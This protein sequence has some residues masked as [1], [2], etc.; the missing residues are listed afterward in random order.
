MFEFFWI[1]LVLWRNFLL[2]FFLGVDF[3]FNLWCCFLVGFFFVLLCVFWEFDVCN[4]FCGDKLSLI[5]L[6]VNL[7][8]NVCFVVVV[9]FWGFLGFFFYL[10]GMDIVKLWCLWLFIWCFDVVFCNFCLILLVLDVVDR[11]LWIVFLDLVLLFW[12]L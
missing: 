11:S 6:L 12:I 10:N 5:L 2:V 9:M 4:L 7:C 8:V 1:W 3:C